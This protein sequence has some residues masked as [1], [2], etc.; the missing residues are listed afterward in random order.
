MKVNCD[1]EIYQNVQYRIES[2]EID[3]GV[4]LVA[5]VVVEC[6]TSLPVF[7]VLDLRK[8]RDS[9]SEVMRRI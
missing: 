9:S 4:E 6:K 5:N 8:A 7:S 2:S 3:R 1:L